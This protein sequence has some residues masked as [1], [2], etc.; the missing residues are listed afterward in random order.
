MSNRIDM[1][2][3]EHLMGLMRIGW[4]DRKINR[5]TGI[6]RTTIARYRKEYQAICSVNAEP[7]AV[8]E[9]A[10]L[11]NHTLQQEHQSVPFAGKQ[12]PTDGVVHFEAP[13]SGT[14]SSTP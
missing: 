2:S 13:T 8:V 1:L 6:H 10:C 12:V 7:A 11:E 14:L 4:S 3:K 9:A 5:V